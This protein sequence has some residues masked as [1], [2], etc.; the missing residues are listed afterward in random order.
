MIRVFSVCKLLDGTSRWWARLPTVGAWT[1]YRATPV[2][3]V[4][5][6]FQTLQFSFH[7]CIPL[8]IFGLGS[9]V[10]MGIAFA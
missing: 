10:Q 9:G 1:T 2:S 4:A 8:V 6:C 7:E 3:I 5:A